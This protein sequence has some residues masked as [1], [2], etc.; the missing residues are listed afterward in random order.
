MLEVKQFRD[1][2]VEPTLKS[3]GMYSTAAERL[4]VG[5]ALAES[6]LV[7]LRQH[8]GGPALG[9]MQ[10]EM[11][12]ARDLLDRYLTVKR[13]DLNARFCQAV[14]LPVIPPVDWSTIPSSR[15][16]RLLTGNLAFSVGL[17]RIRYWMAPE[18]MPRAGE[19]GG[20][21]DYWKRHYNTPLGAGHPAKFT[22]A[23]EA[24]LPLKR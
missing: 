9:V 6:G 4:I 11:A 24:H 23:I 8:G 2:I 22:A 14:F 1:E 12:T 3:M 7:F 19:S 17:A 20:L 15:I 10:I 18:P 16:A 13:P 5:T 21:G